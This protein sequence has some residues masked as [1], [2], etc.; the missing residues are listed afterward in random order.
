MNYYIVNNYALWNWGQPLVFLLQRTW[1][2]FLLI[3][4]IITH[5]NPL[6]KYSIISIWAFSRAM[7]H[8]TTVTK[9]LSV[10][11]IQSLNPQ[12]L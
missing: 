6:S 5:I 3:S 8:P 2:V 9:S 1:E 10:Q 12:S 4:L 11:V 7:S